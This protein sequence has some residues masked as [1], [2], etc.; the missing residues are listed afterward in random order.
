M[1]KLDEQVGDEYYKNLKIQPIEYC[2][3]NGI[4]A[5]EAHAIKYITRH[6]FKNG[7]EDIRKAIHMLEV[8]L[9]LEYG[10]E[11]NN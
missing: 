11:W 9:E 4:P 6:K 5:I 1:S 8:L 7:A 3:H 10:H 2:Y